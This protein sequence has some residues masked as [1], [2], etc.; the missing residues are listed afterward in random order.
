MDSEED[1]TEDLFPTSQKPQETSIRR[2]IGEAAKRQTTE[3]EGLPKTCELMTVLSS[4]GLILDETRD[5]ETLHKLDCEQVGL[6][7]YS[8]VSNKNK[9]SNKAWSLTKKLV[10]YVKLQDFSHFWP[11]FVSK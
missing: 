9:V 1:D 11:I 4:S 7:F 5:I 3:I 2:S 10:Y 6:I 8:R